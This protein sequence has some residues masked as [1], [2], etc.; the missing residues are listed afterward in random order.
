[1][2][3]GVL[4][5]GPCA[6]EVLCDFG[7]SRVMLQFLERCYFFGPVR[8]DYGMNLTKEGQ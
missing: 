2:D 1:V 6:L 5:R 4:G 3:H 7:L 8:T